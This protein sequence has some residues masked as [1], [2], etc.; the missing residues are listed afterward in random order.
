[1][2]IFGIISVSAISRILLSKRDFQLWPKLKLS[3]SVDLYQKRNNAW[4]ICARYSVITQIIDRES[5]L[6][7]NIINIGHNFANLLQK[8]SGPVFIGTQCSTIIV[9]LVLSTA[10]VSCSRTLQNRPSLGH[11]RPRLHSSDFDTDKKVSVHEQSPFLPPGY[12]DLAT[13]WSMHDRT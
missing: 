12:S 3:L 6:S 8:Y 13:L 5:S 7:T 9:L 11:F 10:A 1:M 2:V 4:S